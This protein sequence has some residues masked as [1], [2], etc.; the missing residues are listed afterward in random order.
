MPLEGAV[1]VTAVRRMAAGR[2]NI[3]EEYVRNDMLNLNLA[4]K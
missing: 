4:G 3:V 1:K 2:L